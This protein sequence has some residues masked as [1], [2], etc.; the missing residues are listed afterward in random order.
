MTNTK[1][2]KGILLLNKDKLEC[3]IVSLPSVVSLSFPPSVIKTMEVVDKNA[4][5]THIQSFIQTNKL[6][7]ASFSL[8]IHENILFEKLIPASS[9][10]PVNQP[11]TKPQPVAPLPA[12]PAA[13]QPVAKPQVAPHIPPDHNQQE[14][15]KEDEEE[16]IQRFIDSVPFEDTL[17][18]TIKAPQGT[19][20][21]AANKGMI[22]AIKEAF[23]KADFAVETVYPATQ[24][25]K[26][27]TVTNGLTPEAARLLLQKVDALKQ[28]N[29]LIDEP[30]VTD[31]SPGAVTMGMPKKASDKKRLFILIG[32]F[33]VLILT[34][35]ILFI[36]MNAENAALSR[37]APSPS[38][39]LSTTPIV[40]LSP[41][42]VASTSAAYKQTLPFQITLTPA[43]A[44]LSAQLQERLRQLG[45]QTI[46]L[47]QGSAV[48]TQPLV[49]FSGVIPE[50]V[51]KEVTEAITAVQA[52]TAVQQNTDGEERVI[53]AL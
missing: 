21:I 24:F 43:T 6:P 45:Y 5:F 9:T 3:F 36:R 13:P 10:K 49:V 41:T 39:M 12:Q 2:Q 23:E 28:Q 33:G 14:Q 20:V 15:L 25:G 37:N 48:N 46:L 52:S 31:A 26:E 44:T 32:V 29:M 16:S 1:R 53:I 40:T 34:M 51:K 30:K 35:I 50:D 38:P 8:I 22:L 4:L 47:Q 42:A 17:A 11:P 7:V 18:K 19:L 27:I